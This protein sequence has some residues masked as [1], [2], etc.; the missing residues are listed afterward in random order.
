MVGG[1]FRLNL[2]GETGLWGKM[3]E[4]VIRG[5]DG[6]DGYLGGWLHLSLVSISSIS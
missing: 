5:C 3:R 4:V 2:A 6:V 1:Y